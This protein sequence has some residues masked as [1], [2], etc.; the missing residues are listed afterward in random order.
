MKRSQII[1]ATACLIGLGGAAVVAGGQSTQSFSGR[2]EYRIFCASC[3]GE[4]GKGD[5]PVANS[6]RKK[7]ADLTQLQKKNNGEFPR[8][9]VQKTIDGRTPVSGHGG[10]DMPVWGEVFA[11][12]RES[13]GAEGVKSRVGAIAAF[14]ESIQD[15]R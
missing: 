14:V 1:L 5:G 9:T 15:K 3:H 4:A 10:P 8:E 13:A 11:Q 6:M 12:S 2:E 7:P